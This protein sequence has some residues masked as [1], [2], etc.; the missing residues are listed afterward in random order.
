M[1]IE[2]YIPER[3]NELCARK[4]ISRYQLSA[5]TGISQSALSSISKKKTV[6]TVITLDKICRA[7]GISLSEFFESEGR[8]KS[9]CIT[10]E[11]REVLKLWETLTK[12]EQRFIKICMQS[13]RPLIN[14]FLRKMAKFRYQ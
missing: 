5:M 2:K 6:P 9:G 12:E 10:E 4:K 14:D 8:V 3:M 13:L 1:D 7:L 11:Q